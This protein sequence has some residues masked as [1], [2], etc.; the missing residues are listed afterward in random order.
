MSA[1]ST[2]EK[3]AGS[4][5]QAEDSSKRVKIET[6]ETPTAVKTEEQPST[7]SNRGSSSR[8]G[9]GRRA[10]AGPKDPAKQNRRDW[11]NDRQTAR[12]A[13]EGGG[14][15]GSKDQLGEKKE[16]LPKKKVALLVGYEGTGMQG[17]QM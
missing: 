1:N 5:I 12:E 3:R 2:G 11:V 8:R 15:S 10:G 6:P 14:E 16:R 9:R 17:S 7:T 4:P 13:E